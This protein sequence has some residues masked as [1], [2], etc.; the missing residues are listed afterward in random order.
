MSKW[1]C[2]CHALRDHA[3]PLQNPNIRLHFGYI[4]VIFQKRLKNFL[5]I[6]YLLKVFFS[7]NVNKISTKTYNKRFTKVHYLHREVRTTLNKKNMDS[8]INI[9]IDRETKQK[10]FELAKKKQSKVSTMLKRYILRTI[11]K[12]KNA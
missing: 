4:S 8:N 10:Y 5:I 1:V 7:L 6:S 3:T 11:K 12:N 9:R 2:K